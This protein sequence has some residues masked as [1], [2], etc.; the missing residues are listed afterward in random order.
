M[1]S[2]SADEA[3]LMLQKRIQWLREEMESHLEKQH[4]QAQ[5]IDKLEKQL[6]GSETRVK[7]LEQSNKD[8]KKRHQ[9]EMSAKDKEIALLRSK[10]KGM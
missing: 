2:K 3:N 8:M 1:K 5:K 7:E 4:K 9:E 10:L 6:M